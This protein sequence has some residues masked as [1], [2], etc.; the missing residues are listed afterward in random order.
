M[1][2]PCN[3]AH[4]RVYVCS[5]LLLMSPDNTFIQG[6]AIWQQKYWLC[7]FLSAKCIKG[8]GLKKKHQ[9]QNLWSVTFGWWALLKSAIIFWKCGLVIISQI[10]TVIEMKINYSVKYSLQLLSP[11]TENEFAE[12]IKLCTMKSDSS[13]IFASQ[14]FIMNYHNMIYIFPIFVYLIF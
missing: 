9:R 11:C 13:F 7:V 8:Y 3:C 12:Q 2:Q 14:I 5:V 1:I 6:K 4:Y 10:F